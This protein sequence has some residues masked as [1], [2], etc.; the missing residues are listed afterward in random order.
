MELA[1]RAGVN[2][3]TEAA[4]LA[5]FATSTDVGSDRRC[6]GYFGEAVIPPFAV[7]L[8][9]KECPAGL[10]IAHAPIPAGYT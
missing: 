9:A 5:A 6:H 10:D 7:N 3:A 8:P 2:N 1:L 4:A